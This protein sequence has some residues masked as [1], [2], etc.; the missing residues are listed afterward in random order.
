MINKVLVINSGSTSLRYKV[1]NI[2]TFKKVVS[3]NIQ[4]IGTGKFK[5]HKQALKN[6]IREIGDLGDIKAVGHRV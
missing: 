5:N 3:G 4:N 1:F 6:I 2:T